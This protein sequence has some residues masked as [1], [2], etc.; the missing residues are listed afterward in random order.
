MDAAVEISLVIP[1]LNEADNLKHLYHELII[2]LGKMELEYELIFVDDGSTDNSFQIIKELSIADRRVSGC[3]LSR[4]FGHQVALLAGIQRAKGNVVVTIDADLQ[5]P[6]E[7]IPKLYAEYINGNDIVNTRRTDPPRTGF[8]KRKS[9]RLFYHF[10]NM[11]A[12][13]RIEPAS[14]DF[15]LMSRKAVECFLQIEERDRFTRGLVSWMGFK[16]AI[17]A[18]EASERFAGQSK[19]SL[20]KMIKLGLDGIT[21][22]S[23]K[24]L[25][26][27]FFAG[28]LLSLF[29]L[30]YAIFAIINYFRGATI[31]GWTSI[32]VTVLVISGFQLISIGVI[33][34]YIARIFNEAKRRPAFFIRETTDT[35]E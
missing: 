34:E 10:V 5:H 22:F 19:Y 32:L 16:Q 28:L 33:G 26:L 1:L 9:S 15:R 35:V 27:S 18:Y 17:V 31:E 11:L 23:A 8:F 14:S 13:V 29:G 25:R 4:N 21:S 24:P 12:D 7:V 2:T 20:T 3:A 6:P 30:L